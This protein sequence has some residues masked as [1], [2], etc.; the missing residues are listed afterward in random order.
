MSRLLLSRWRRVRH[1][2]RRRMAGHDPVLLGSALA[3]AALGVVMV[4][5]ATR[6]LPDRARDLLVRRLG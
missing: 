5:A 4:G 2:L 6:L 3:L 1:R